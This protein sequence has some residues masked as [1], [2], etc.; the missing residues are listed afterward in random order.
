[1]K[2]S[3]RVL[4]LVILFSLVLCVAQPLYARGKST[5]S[6]GMGL[7]VSV[8]ASE[9]ELLQAAQEVA[10]DGIIQG[11]KEYNKDE[12]VGGAEVVDAT[13]VLGKVVGSG[14]AFY[15]N[16]KKLLDRRIFKE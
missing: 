8:P 1:M 13:P 14:Q 7:S 10:A 5:E 3:M 15:K 4:D 11:R 16:R 12:Y 6:Y 9:S 2:R